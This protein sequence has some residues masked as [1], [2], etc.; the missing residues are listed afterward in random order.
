[1]TEKRRGYELK[2]LDPGPRS[3]CRHWGIRV[4][5]GYDPATGKRLRPYETFEGSEREADLRAMAIKVQHGIVTPTGMT[6]GEFFV[7][8]Y[9]PWAESRVRAGSYEGG[10]RDRDR[11]TRETYRGY[12]QAV[13]LYIVPLFGNVGMADLKP[14]FVQM[15]LNTIERL[16]ARRNA[17]K[18]LR[19]G[20]RRARAWGLVQ[21]V[22]T[23]AVPEPR[24]DTPPKQTAK[25]AEVWECIEAF[26]DSDDLDVR[27]A[28]AVGFGVGMRRSE[29]CAMDKGEI[30]WSVEDES[31]L[32]AYHIWR[33]YHWRNGA[34]WFEPPKSPKSDRTVM[35]PRWL[36]EM[37]RPYDEGEGPLLVHN[38]ERTHPDRI[39][40][41]WRDVMMNK[42]LKVGM[43]FKNTRHSCG[44]ILVRE[45]RLNVADVQQLF[46]HS[47]MAITTEFYV[48]SG[49][50][51]AER[52][53]LAMSDVRP[54]IVQDCPNLRDS[55]R[56]DGEQSDYASS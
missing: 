20:Y 18:T 2:Q 38:G 46:G 26:D 35:F 6:V 53:A 29:I 40:K 30:D 32:G 34:G 36:G 43:P 51:S 12:E 49:V 10:P 21:T 45:K 56:M 48:Q 37:L 4:S 31:I 8:M 11:I 3:R 15:R 16:G 27:H 55:G 52:A 54:P 22:P 9:L 39:T 7:G 28:V 25:A 1:M 44:T 13:R 47:T 5:V 50:E 33:G 19:Q 42:G 24:Y 41:R 17:Y 14:Y 23:D